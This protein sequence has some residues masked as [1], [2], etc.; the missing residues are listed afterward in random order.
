MIDMVSNSDRFTFFSSALEAFTN[1]FPVLTHKAI[2]KKFQ[3]VETIQMT[4]FD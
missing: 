4:A 2:H 1:I 3:M